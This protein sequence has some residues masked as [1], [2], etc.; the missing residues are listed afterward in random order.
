MVHEKLIVDGET[1]ISG[2]SDDMQQEAIEV[3]MGIPFTPACALAYPPISDR[4]DEQI[5]HRK[6]E[7][8]S[9]S[10]SKWSSEDL[11]TTD[12]VGYC[13]THQ[14]GGMSSDASTGTSLLLTPCSSIRGK[15]LPGIASSGGTLAALSLMVRTICI[16]M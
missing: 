16:V 8:A 14:E 6:G 9:E 13:T 3:C 15:E 1:H 12:C 7:R 4:G 11:L 2:Q 5:Y 10:G